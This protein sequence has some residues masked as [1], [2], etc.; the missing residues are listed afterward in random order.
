[1]DSG[2]PGLRG[3]RVVVLATSD[4][5]RDVN[6]VYRLGANSFLVKPVAF[7]LL[8]QRFEDEVMLGFDGAGFDQ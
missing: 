5:A 7:E 8:R 1:M 3:L 4:Q 6:M 2:T